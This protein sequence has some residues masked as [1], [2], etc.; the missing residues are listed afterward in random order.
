M[1]E[2]R[3]KMTAEVVARRAS[4]FTSCEDCVF[5]SVKNCESLQFD[6][7]IP[8]CEGKYRKDG[9]TCYFSLKSIKI[10]ERKKK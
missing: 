7:I 6:G 10:N 9:K 4:A 5:F 3:F 8:H 1:N 2:K